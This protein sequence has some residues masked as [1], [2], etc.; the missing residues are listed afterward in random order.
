MGSSACLPL[1]RSTATTGHRL[2][3]PDSDDREEGTVTPPFRIAA[4][5]CERGRSSP[6]SV[7][8]AGAMPSSDASSY[9]RAASSSLHG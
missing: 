2:R 5:A 1:A 7:T 9:R 6:S 4:S 3:R 8:K